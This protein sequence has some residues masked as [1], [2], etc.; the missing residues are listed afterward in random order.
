M[1]KYKSQFF[2]AFV[3]M[4]FAFIITYQIKSISSKQEVVVTNDSADILEEVKTLKDQKK[5]LEGKLSE[6][7]A[8]VED[9]E[10]NAGENSSYAK[11][12]LEE[13]EKSRL[14]S[15]EVEV[16]G[17][18][19]E[20]NISP[21]SITFSGEMTPQALITHKELII[22]I[23]E[24]FFSGAEAVSINDIRVTNYTGIRSSSGGAYIFVGSE[25][26]SPKQV[27]TIRAIGDPD[28]L[29]KD[30]DFPGTF[31]G[32][33]LSS[34]NQPTYEKKDNIIIPKTKEVV[35]FKFSQKVVN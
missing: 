9:Y 32:I 20:I 8:Q 33:P 30:L 14:V 5:Q 2:I 22:I 27:I 23:N 13:L 11:N 24:L 31:D 6:I 26:I 10:K 29:K 17:S 25:K 21:K 3:C 35:T 34:Y 19:V 18:G 28:K 12:L 15:G 7:Q 4:I 16:T 1:K